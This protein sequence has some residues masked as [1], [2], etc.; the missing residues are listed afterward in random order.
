MAL[1]EAFL[2]RMQRLLGEEYPAFLDSLSQQ[3]SGGLRVH[4]E[5]IEPTAFAARAP[6][7]LVPV[8]WAA[9]GFAYGEGDRPGLHPWHD[10]GVYYMQEPSAMAVGALADPKPGERVLDLCAAPGGKTTH[11]AG[12]MKRQGI[13]IANEIHPQR[14][15]VL[16]QNI[17]RMGI[18]HCAVLN[19][20]PERLAARFAGYFDCVVVDAPCSGEGMFRKDDTA[21]TEWTPDSPARCAVRQSSILDAAAAMM[22]PGGRMIYSTCTFSPEENEG[23][24]SRFLERHPEFS[25]AQVEMPYF[26]AGHPEWI[27]NGHLDV[28]NT[29]RL[30][31]HRLH[32]EGHYVAALY[33]TDG[34]EGSVPVITPMRERDV[35]T[36]WLSLSSE[37]LTRPLNGVLQRGRDVLWLV[38]KDMP[39]L[40][41]LK[42]RR[43]GIELGTLRRGR[44]N[45]A[46]ALSH[47]LMPTHI[48]RMVSYPAES[49]E[50]RR[51]LHGETLPTTQPKG[52]V[53]VGADE[54]PLGW[55]K[56][57]G[58]ILKNHY[59][60]GL[61]RVGL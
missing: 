20:T 37:L 48:A 13:L 4:P 15:A 3:R 2:S 55:G 29:F 46:H 9:E 33:K 52:W 19:E 50:I 54:F 14:A 58:G 1:P 39:E 32:G 30:W 60:K 16:A 44:M 35:P 38:P 26:A 61:R 25:V 40:R 10:A 41:G 31:P 49:E 5:K 12:R 43:V 7:S 24:I 28:Q 8:P 22:R 53:I 17:E 11:L 47:A 59:P 27:E 42:V 21:V 51:Y 18:P 6:F 36:D 23:S 57:A 56:S 34:D 45:P